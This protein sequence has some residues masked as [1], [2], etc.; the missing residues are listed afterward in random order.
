MIL[1]TGLMCFQSK[2]IPY[3]GRALYLDHKLDEIA[4]SLPLNVLH[5]R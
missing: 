2:F 1:G 5:V 4:D 3:A